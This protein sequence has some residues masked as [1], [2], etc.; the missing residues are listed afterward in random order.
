MLLLRRLPL[1]LI[2]TLA[3]LGMALSVRALRGP[4]SISI[5]VNRPVNAQCLFGLCLNT[6]LLL[7]KSN[8]NVKR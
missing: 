5:S 7:G 1:I 2:T 3:F 8:P 6:L 4:F